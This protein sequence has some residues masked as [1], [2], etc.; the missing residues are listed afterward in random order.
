MNSLL[1][2]IEAHTQPDLRRR[3]EVPEWGEEGKPL[4]IT[5]Q[6]MT[7]DDLAVVTELEG[8]QWHKQ[9]PRIVVMKAC[10]EAGTKLFKMVD[11]NFLRE[12]AAPDVVNRI[13][14]SI[15]GRLTVEEAEKN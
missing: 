4:V 3:F 14:L 12:R 2:R 15:M 6:M 11:A 9:A 5:Y 7:L 13:A 8:S 10:D 1:E